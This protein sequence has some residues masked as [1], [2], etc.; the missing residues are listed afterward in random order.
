M[1]Y[2]CFKCAKDFIS[3][4]VLTL[5]FR[6]H[7][8]LSAN[9]RYIC[10]KGGCQREFSMLKQFRR[11]VYRDHKEL[12]N[13]VTSSGAEKNNDVVAHESEEWQTACCTPFAS[14][15]SSNSSSVLYVSIAWIIKGQKFN[16]LIS[17]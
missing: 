5:H 8:S 15:D 10:N 17:K 7:H 14:G 16:L 1:S 2:K 3:F 4:E 13:F 6:V 9:D 12:F 11:H